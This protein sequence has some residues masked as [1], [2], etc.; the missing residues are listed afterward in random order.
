[1]CELG[2]GET[3]WCGGGSQIADRLWQALYAYTDGDTSLMFYLLAILFYLLF[4]FFCFLL[5]IFIS[6]FKNIFHIA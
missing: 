2:E 5:Y 6:I 1:M 3:W 4:L